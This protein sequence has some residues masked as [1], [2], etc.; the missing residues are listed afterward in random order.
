MRAR[1]SKGEHKGR[2]GKVI[3]ANE[4]GVTIMLER[5]GVPSPEDIITITWDAVKLIT[6]LVTLFRRI[7]NLFKSKK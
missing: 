4:S 6:A 3:R 7:V 5:D 1:V 2:E